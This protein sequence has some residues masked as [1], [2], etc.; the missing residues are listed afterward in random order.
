MKKTITLLVMLMALLQPTLAAD[1]LANNN[2]Y[3]LNYFKKSGTPT[4]VYLTCN[5]D[6][7][8]NKSEHNIAFTF[9][10]N[11][12]WYNVRYK[13]LWCWYVFTFGKFD[14]DYKIYYKEENDKAYTLATEG[15]TYYVD[16][17]I[18]A[19][20]AQQVKF[21][22]T[23]AAILNKPFEHTVSWN[24]PKELKTGTYYFKLELSVKPNDNIPTNQYT[25]GKHYENGSNSI[26]CTYESAM[27]Y[28][29]SD[30]GIVHKSSTEN[31]QTGGKVKI[32]YIN[33]NKSI[34][35]SD[36][37]KNPHNVEGYRLVY[38]HPDAEFTVR[39]SCQNTPAD[40]LIDKQNY[41]GYTQFLCGI[42]ENYRVP[43]YNEYVKE[44]TPWY[45]GEIPLSSNQMRYTEYVK[46][47]NPT[48]ASFLQKKY[49]TKQYVNG[50]SQFKSNDRWGTLR[51]RNVLLQTTDAAC[52]NFNE[53]AVSKLKDYEKENNE[54]F[55]RT[56][57]I[58]DL[59]YVKLPQTNLANHT[60]FKVWNKTYYLPKN[61]LDVTMALGC[62]YYGPIDDHIKNIASSHESYPFSYISEQCLMFKLLPQVAF[63][64]LSSAEK[65]TQYVCMD[66]TNLSMPITL[67]G[68]EI[69]CTTA[70]PSLYN[71][72]YTWQMSQNLNTW[73]NIEDNNPHVVNNIEY[74]QADNKNTHLVLKSSI[75][76]GNKPLY[77]RQ[78]CV[79]KTFSS[80]QQSQ[81]YNYP[82]TIGGKTNY[83]ISVSSDYYTVQ[84]LPTLLDQHVAFTGYHWPETT[85]LCHND[86]LPAPNISFGIVPNNLTDK[87]LEAFNRLTQYKVYQLKNGNK[88]LVSNT[89][90]YVLP[91][92]QDSL[93]LECVVATCN[94]S[95]SKHVCLYR[96]KKENISFT[97][98]TANVGIAVRDSA[99][100]LLVLQ[101]LQGTSPTLWFNETANNST[102]WLRGCT[103][104]K[105]PTLLLYPWETMDRNGCQALFT[106]HHWDFYGETGFS[107]DDA[108]LSQLRDYG[109]QKQ[110]NH[111]A[112]QEQ[113]AIADSIA[114]N[115]WKMVDNSNQNALYLPNDSAQSPLYYVKKQTDRGC[116]SDSV[117]VK[118][119]WVAPIS[120]NQ[121]HFKNS[122]SDTVSVVSGQG[123]PYIVG[124]F[125]VNG[126]YGPV[127]QDNG[128][129]YTYQWMRKS[130]NGQWEP[131]V[132]NSR[133]YAQVTDSGTKI[134]NS[135]TKYVSLPDETLKNIQEP[136]EI[137]RFVYSTKHGDKNSQIVS[138]SNSLWM[139]SSPVL[140]SQYIQVKPA[141]CPNDVVSITVTEPDNVVDKHTRY[142]WKLSAEI[143]PYSISSTLFSQSQN[144]CVIEQVKKDLT[145]LVYR[146]NQRTG[147]VSN[148]VEI[149][150]S[151]AHFK[152]GFGIVFNHHTYQLS[153]KLTV[154]PGSK[155][156]LI[157]LSVNAQ[158]N[159]NEWVL[160]IQDNF[161]GDGN[162]Y[163]GTTSNAVNPTCYLY[164]VGQHK[165]KLTT[166]A[167]NGCSETIV[168]ENIFVQGTTNRNMPTSHFESNEADASNALLLQTVYPTVLH[169]DNGY[170][171]QIKTNKTAYNVA[172]YNTIG[173]IVLQKTGLHGNSTFTLTGMP[174]GTYLL[175]VDN[176]RYKLIKL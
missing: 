107:I 123:N 164:N 171:V 48:I 13:Y 167:A 62:T 87:E 139:V 92:L 79:L 20:E 111:N 34:V 166:T 146:Y 4:D 67:S 154:S 101:A 120:G 63:L 162:S 81:L 61:E 43:T 23:V 138:V 133:L 169:A 41:T 50:Y 142:A 143:V 106:Q 71:P 69:A 152:G 49:D 115:S 52:K 172:L 22:H 58:R 35:Y 73:Y 40:T 68:K 136:W 145:V 18:Q 128:N 158:D 165:I 149:P 105:A 144:K 24:F 64:P 174:K 155:I 137:C 102:Y 121:I 132:I 131:I 44:L 53:N 130:S 153:D 117:Q 29:N 19:H 168:A 7:L 127:S 163:N 96:L 77:F 157:N 150:I 6:V 32:S 45:N 135:G 161:M 109:K 119:E 1:F 42:G 175:Q 88:T 97:N 38:N 118:V 93:L 89:P 160:Q 176:T 76:K 80:T 86:S 74:R 11:L 12:S 33:S 65:E 9:G 47:C 90:N 60:I 129:S 14:I 39:L 28:I 116:W 95:V 27:K 140:D 114:Q 26:T 113:L 56:Y 51:F 122:A 66:T 148:T 85:Y 21:E 55:S 83:Y 94:D 37:L 141:T 124:S 110:T 82:I 112:L 15:T 8:S 103:P 46:T 72:M 70:S 151:A 10:G 156:E 108:T 31:N 2:Q 5:Q 100:R 78:V 98:I 134:I 54:W 84:A 173:Q 147:V 126:G 91:A 17:D 3:L 36:G 59:N 170:T 104:K 30:N 99:Q 57:H 125:P 75:L 16:N 25:V 159:L